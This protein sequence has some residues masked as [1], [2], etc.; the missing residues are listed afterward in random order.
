VVL[1]LAILVTILRFYKISRVASVL[2]WPYLIWVTF[3]SVLN[4]SIWLL[5]P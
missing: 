4:M 5:N 3:A 1:W 2:M